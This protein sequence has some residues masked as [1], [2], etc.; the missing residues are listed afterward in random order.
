V[1]GQARA[2]IRAGSVER[3]LDV[4]AAQALAERARHPWRALQDPVMDDVWRALCAIFLEL[5]QP[6]RDD[7]QNRDC[8]QDARTACRNLATALVESGKRHGLRGRMKR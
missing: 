5:P 8:G 4:A 7:L 1:I 3:L 6:I 2:A